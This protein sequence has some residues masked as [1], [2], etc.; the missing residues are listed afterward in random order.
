MCV[1]VLWIG[2]GGYRGV[3][4]RP[5]CLYTKLT[6]SFIYF[7]ATV[8]IEENMNNNQS[9]VD[10]FVHSI[11]IWNSEMDIEDSNME[12]IEMRAVNRFVYSDLINGGD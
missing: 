2:I 11:Q 4:K 8:L 12:N 10:A 5:L 1:G 7:V 9:F 3:Y 6:P